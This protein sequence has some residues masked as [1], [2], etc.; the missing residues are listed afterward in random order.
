MRHVLT[1]GL[2]L[3][4][5]P[6]AAI[7][8]NSLLQT[9][10]E[11]V[12]RLDGQLQAVEGRTRGLSIVSSDDGEGGAKIHATNGLQSLS[13]IKNETKTSVVLEDGSVRV[14]DDLE[15]NIRIQ[16]RVR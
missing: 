13:D 6:F 8:Q 10:E 1:T 4:G 12:N 9:D 5:L 2:V 16:F 3:C 14:S 15:I 11:L 7:A